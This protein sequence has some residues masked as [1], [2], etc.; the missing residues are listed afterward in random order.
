LVG[1]ARCAAQTGGR[2]AAPRSEL[3]A[4]EMLLNS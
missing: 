1:F 4:L 2:Y 3:V